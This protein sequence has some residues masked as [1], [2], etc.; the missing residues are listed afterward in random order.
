MTAPCD[1][2]VY[3]ADAA[4]DYFSTDFVTPVLDAQQNVTLISAE[5]VDNHTLIVASRPLDT[6]DP[7]DFAVQV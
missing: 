4:G 5:L 1:D 6:C 7:Q 3:A 2:L